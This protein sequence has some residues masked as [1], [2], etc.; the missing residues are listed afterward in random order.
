MKYIDRKKTAARTL[1]AFPRRFLF[2]IDYIVV[3]KLEKLTFHLNTLA[4]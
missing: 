2:E 4:I 3:N 1:L